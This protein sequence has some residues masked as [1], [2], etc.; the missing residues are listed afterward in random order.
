MTPEPCSQ[1]GLADLGTS[2]WGSP[3]PSTGVTVVPNRT[4]VRETE[5]SLGQTSAQV[6]QGCWMFVSSLHL[7][8]REDQESLL[9][10]QDAGLDMLHEIVTR[11]KGM[12]QQIFREVGGGGA[13]AHRLAPGHRTERAD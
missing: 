6:R 8:V 10:Q 12:G 1:G 5:K 7:Q 4:G 9:A 11:Q 3:A 2:G 13:R